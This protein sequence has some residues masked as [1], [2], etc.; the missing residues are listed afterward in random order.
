MRGLKVKV[1]FLT[2]KQLSGM[3]MGGIILLLLGLI[4]SFIS[5]F[6]PAVPTTEITPIYQGSGETK[7]ISFAVNVDWGEEFIPEMIEVFDRHQIRCTFFL[8]GRWTEKFPHL[9]KAL[10]D[11]NHEIGNHGYKHDSPNKM[12]LEQVKNDILKAESIIKSATG[13]MTQL[14]APPSGERKTHVLKASHELGYRT[15]LWSIDTIDW[16]R[17]AP[18]TIVTRVLNKAH[19][20][21]IILM[22]PTAPTIKA[23]PVIISELLNQGYSLVPVSENINK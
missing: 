6:G 17:P 7:Q 19:N 11:K 18:E 12:S 8:T 20:G 22:H 14:Y 23:L 10:A 16:Q 9:A 2:K 1:F 3:I 5:W 13:K 4:I 15:V 21:A